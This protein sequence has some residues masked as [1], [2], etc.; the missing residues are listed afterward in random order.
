MGKA[1][2]HTVF[3]LSAALRDTADM[4]QIDNMRSAAV[5]KGVKFRKQFIKLRAANADK[6]F[7]SVFQ[8]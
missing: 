5:I 6:Q 7:F 8:I 2:L 1:Q 4:V 3:E